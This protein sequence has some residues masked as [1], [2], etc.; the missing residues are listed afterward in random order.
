VPIRQLKIDDIRL[1]N[2]F[3]KKPNTI[4]C[5]SEIFEHSLLSSKIKLSS[6]KTNHKTNLDRDFNNDFREIWLAARRLY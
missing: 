3:V 4:A 2:K 5:N 1:L 6:K